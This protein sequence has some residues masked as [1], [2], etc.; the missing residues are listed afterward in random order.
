MTTTKY[1][2]GVKTNNWIPF[3]KKLW[4]RNY[5]ERIIRNEAE[6]AKIAE[7]INNNPILWSRHRR[8]D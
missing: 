8:R 1:I 6:Y 4:Q 5:H 3:N 7:Y 2:H